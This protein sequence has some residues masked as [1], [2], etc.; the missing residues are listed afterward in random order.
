MEPFIGQIMLFAFT[1][2]PR[3]W[4][5]C[6]GQLL[7]IAQYQAL[8]ALI[9]T[10][11]GGDGISS[12]AVPD[13]RGRI[14]LGMGH[15]PGLSVY[16]VGDKVGEET[17]TLNVAEMPSHSHA[18]Q[19]SSQSPAA[20]ATAVPGPE[21]EFATA[22]GAGVTRYAAQPGGAPATLNPAS[23]GSSGASH[24]HQ[25]MMPTTVMNYCIAY[26]GIFPSRS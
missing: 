3:G 8:F 11:Y 16:K 7:H 13:L 15:A 10:Q 17:V 12:F 9:G 24:P 21:V 22:D 6:Q 20:N 26:D 25:N 19:A 4:L 23:I 5:S 14:P 18:I 1:R 2:V